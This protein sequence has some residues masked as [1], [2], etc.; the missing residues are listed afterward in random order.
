MGSGEKAVAVATPAPAV[1]ATD[2]AATTTSAQEEPV[3]APQPRK[4]TEICEAEDDNLDDLE[5]QVR[6]KALLWKAQGSPQFQANM[7]VTLKVLFG[8]YS[9]PFQNW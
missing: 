7:F 9:I 1:P 2:S 5:R 3:A 4:E 6:E 8:L